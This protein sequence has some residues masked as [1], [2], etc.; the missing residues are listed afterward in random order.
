MATP[1]AQGR[2]QARGQIRVAAEAYIT[3]VATLDPSCISN[4]HCSLQQH[5]I[6]NPLSEAR[7]GTCILMETTSGP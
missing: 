1:V 6:F 5:R 7:D 4:L 2:S 3:A